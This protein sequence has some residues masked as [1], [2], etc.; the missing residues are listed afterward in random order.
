MSLS[1][2]YL[3]QNQFGVYYFR[4]RIPISIRREFNLPKTEIKKSLR[5]TNRREALQLARILWVDMAKNKFMSKEEYNDISNDIHKQDEMLVTGRELLSE[6]NKIHDAPDCIPSDID[7]YLERLAPHQIEALKCADEYFAEKKAL[8]AKKS[9]VE[10]V[11]VRN[12]QKTTTKPPISVLLE[13][14]VNDFKD[15]WKSRTAKKDV[16]PIIT[17]LIEIIG[18]KRGDDISI[19]DIVN[20]KNDY[21]KVPKWRTTKKD[22]KG[23][24]ISELLA[25]TIPKEHIQSPKTLKKKFDIVKQ[26]LVWADDNNYLKIPAEKLKKPLKRDT[27]KKRIKNQAECVFH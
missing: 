5:V 7:D 23:K 4:C 13:R 6:L 1:P 2:S 10:E 18:D 9:K 15:D 22:Y 19:D 12:A 25:M 20:F 26:F 11:P 21:K 8:Q 27:S 14:F 3:F 16:I 24:G 17:E